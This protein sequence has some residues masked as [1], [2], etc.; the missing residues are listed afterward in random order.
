VLFTQWVVGTSPAT[1]VTHLVAYLGVNLVA[2]TAIA[3][4]VWHLVE[5][6]ALALKDVWAPRRAS[7]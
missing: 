1:R 5:K 4:G 2:S 7:V 3:V 6:R